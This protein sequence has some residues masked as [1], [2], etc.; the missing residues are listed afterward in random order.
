MR[1]INVKN[2][3]KELCSRTELATMQSFFIDITDFILHNLNR[4]FINVVLYQSYNNVI[5]DT[6]G[7]FGGD[8]YYSKKPNETN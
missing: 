7:D 3:K 5:D 8:Y 2:F 1:Y 4:E 6:S